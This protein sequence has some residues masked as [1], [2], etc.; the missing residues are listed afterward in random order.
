MVDK[1]IEW[2][3]RKQRETASEI[4][5]LRGDAGRGAGRRDEVRAG[6]SDAR[7]RDAAKTDT[8]VHASR[9][10]GMR[11][12]DVETEISP[13]ERYLVGHRDSASDKKY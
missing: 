12:R 9:R 5:D 11:V 6:F 1:G 4:L 2:K 7:R 10:P 8:P 13:F 3:R